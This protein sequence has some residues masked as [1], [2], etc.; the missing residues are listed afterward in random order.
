VY[1]Q[2]PVKKEL[3]EEQLDFLLKK[4]IKLLK[5]EIEKQTLTE[6]SVARFVTPKLGDRD[7]LIYII[8]PWVKEAA[9]RIENE[10]LADSNIS[11]LINYNK[12]N[13]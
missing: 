7:K 2:Q 5:P 13:E 11:S 12:N 10:K 4:L 8:L 6:E 1:T 3:N 9:I